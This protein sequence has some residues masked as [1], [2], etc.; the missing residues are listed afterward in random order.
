[1]NLFPLPSLIKMDQRFDNVDYHFYHVYKLFRPSSG[2]SS[3]TLGESIQWRRSWG[4]RAQGHPIL[5]VGG[6]CHITGPP[7]KMC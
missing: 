5:S 4:G 6:P 3:D 2:I 1:M 7:N